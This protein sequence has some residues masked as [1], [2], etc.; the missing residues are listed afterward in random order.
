MPGGGL[1]GGAASGAAAGS[2]A[3]PVGAIGGALIGAAGSL[4]SSK[5]SSDFAEKAYK[6]RYQ[7]QVKDLQKAGLNP[8]LAVQNSPGSVPQPNFENAGEAAV[9]GYSAA[10]QSKAVAQQVELLKEQTNSAR[11]TNQKTLQE[12]E[13]TEM[14][15]LVFKASPLYQSAKATLGEHGEVTGPSA[16]ASDKFKADLEY[17]RSQAASLSENAGVQRLQADLLKGEKTLQELKIKY[18]DEL[19]AVEVAYRRAMQNAASAQVP[20]AQADAEFWKNAGPL[21]KWASYIKSI[22]K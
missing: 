9:K 22:L 17:T 10:M 12:A 21:A 3:G 18:A 8:M 6:H 7:W 1:I 2:I 16:A 4:F 15:N 11:S 13:S 14:A 20:A 19:A 5:Q